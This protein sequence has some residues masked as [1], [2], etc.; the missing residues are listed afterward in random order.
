ME[1]QRHP[2]TGYFLLAAFVVFLTWYFLA[3][4]LGHHTVVRVQ[5]RFLTTHDDL[6]AVDGRHDGNRAVVGKFGMILLTTDG[7]KTWRERPSGT[8]KALSAI[9]FA[10]PQHGFVVGSGG[11]VLETSDGGV[12]WKPQN[13]GTRDQLLG[14]C[15]VSPTVAYAVG[16]FGTVLSTSDGGEQWSRHELSWGKLIPRIIKESGEL[17]PNLNAVHFV[18]GQTGW[19]VGEFGLVLESGDGG[20]TWSA[21]NYGSELPQL[22]DVTFR[23]ER[24]GWAVGQQGTLIQTLDGGKHWAGIDLGTKKNLYGITLDKERGVIVG[25]GIAFVSH[26]GG[27]SWKRLESVADTRWLSGITLKSKEAIAVGQGGTIRLLELDEDGSKQA[28]GQP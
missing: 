20:Q 23:D 5:E 7:G 18:N 25:D 13:S 3:S 16:A 1:T 4:Y 8:A 2:L 21:Q 17:E 11:T 26:D 24:A 10:D 12:S 9:A 19:I 22:F 14:V 28:A 6:F 15:A 27:S